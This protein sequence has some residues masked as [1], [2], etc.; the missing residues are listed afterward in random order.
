MDNTKEE[1]F[2]EELGKIMD[3]FYNEVHTPLVNLVNK[4]KENENTKSLYFFTYQENFKKLDDM[5]LLT[6]WV[7]DHID[8]REAFPDS[9]TYRGSLTQ[10]IRK[11]LGFTV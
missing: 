10:K 9:K 2:L 7:T 11:A 5:A 8:D 3:K 6:A 1:K 4:Y